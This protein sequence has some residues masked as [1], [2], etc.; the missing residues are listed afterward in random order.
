MYVEGSLGG[1]NQG[2][3]VNYSAWYQH[4]GLAG[5]IVSG[6]I[7]LHERERPPPDGPRGLSQFQG[8]KEER[9]LNLR[10]APFVSHVFSSSEN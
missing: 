10:L 7:F 1:L 8:L 3:D 6:P 2:V 5:F 4:S 9:L